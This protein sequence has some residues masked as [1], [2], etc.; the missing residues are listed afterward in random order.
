ML[1]KF[2]QSFS[3]IILVV[4]T[5]FCSVGM[6][7]KAVDPILVFSEKEPG[8]NV[9]YSSN[10]FNSTTEKLDNPYQGFYSLT[11]FNITPNMSMPNIRMGDLDTRLLLVE[12]NIS[13]FKDDDISQNALDTMDAILSKFDEEGK[14]VVLRFLYDWNGRASQYEPSS[15]E[16]VKKHMRQVSPVVN[17]HKDMILLHQGVFVGNVAEMHAS[18]FNSDEEMTELYLTLEEAFDK[19]VFLGV[20]TPRYHRLFAAAGADVKRIAFFNDGMFGSGNDLGTYSVEGYDRATELDFQD[21]YARYV[22]SGGEVTLEADESKIENCIPE[23]FLMHISHLNKAHYAPTLN[24]WKYSTYVSDDM[25]NGVSG[26]DYIEN[27]FGYRYELTGFEALAYKSQESDKEYLELDVELYNSGF[28]SAM[29]RFK[30]YIALVGENGRMLTLPMD[31]N[32][33]TLH[34]LESQKY[35]VRIPVEWLEKGELMDE[36]LTVSF[37]ITDPRNGEKIKIATDCAKD[38][39]SHYIVGVVRCR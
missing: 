18:K 5:G 21:Y 26:Y 19:E 22:P 2:K 25:W 32:M 34:S 13:S 20:R 4:L 16:V 38:D 15:L 39:N 11:G 17:A 14:S 28:A 24:R 31:G 29:K 27:H 12:F 6:T 37:F 36:E 33:T 10:Q 23:M 8:L 1:N 7:F 3:L 30:P 9:V 35:K